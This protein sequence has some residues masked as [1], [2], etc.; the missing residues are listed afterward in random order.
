MFVA[1]IPGITQLIRMFSL[2]LSTRAVP[3]TQFRTPA[4]APLYSGYDS[5]W[6]DSGNARGRYNR[7]TG[8]FI[9]AHEM[10]S[11]LGS[12]YDAFVVNVGTE[13]IGSRWNLVRVTPV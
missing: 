7:P 1:T 10:Y 13:K 2:I 3:L 9:L 8:R 5:L 6:M 4:L 11:Q 12:I